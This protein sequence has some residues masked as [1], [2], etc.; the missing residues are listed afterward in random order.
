[1]VKKILLVAIYEDLLTSLGSYQAGVQNDYIK[2]LIYALSRKS[3]KVDVLTHWSNPTDPSMEIINDNLRVI[4]VSTDKLQFVPKDEMYYLLPDFYQELNKKLDLNTYDI[5]HTDYW[6]SGILGHIIKKDFNLS[7]IHTS[8]SLGK[9]KAKEIGRFNKL[10][11]RAESIIF[12]NADS[13]IVTTEDEKQAIRNH[14]NLE[15]KIAVIPRGVDSIF[16]IPA[17][18]SL[19]PGKYF[20]YTGRLEDDKGIQTLIDAFKKM[21]LKTENDIKLVIAGGGSR[22]KGDFYIPEKVKRYIKGMEDNIIFTGRLPQ[23]ELMK[24]YSHALATIVPSYDESFGMAAAESQATGVP[25][26]ATKVGRLQEA[27]IDEVTGYLF[28]KKDTNYLSNLML[29]MYENDFV[30]GKL[31]KQAR[32]YAKNNFNWDRI[33][34]RITLLY[35]ELTNEYEREV[36]LSN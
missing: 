25:V 11:V 15:A 14:Y 10:R 26:L 2:Q 23:R 5:I 30:R 27:V 33:T 24:I 13:V 32:E 29:K 6:L 3:Y 8:H 21:Q 28:D 20:L 22:N 17:T 36:H 7:W 31:G 4:R 18:T 12:S 9:L 34:N 16:F 19:I 1:M 35:K